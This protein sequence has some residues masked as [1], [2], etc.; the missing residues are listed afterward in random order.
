M[1]EARALTVAGLGHVALFAALSLS[2][3][4]M[5]DFEPGFDDP[6]PVDFVEIGDVPS[7]VE[8][9]PPTLAAAPRETIDAP[10]IEE[11]V[12]EEPEPEP[13]PDLAAETPPPEAT[14]EPVPP[15]PK[16]KPA[17]AKELTQAVDKSV[18]EAPTAREEQDFA[19]AITDALPQQ[20]RLSS[21]QQ[22]TLAQ[23]IKDRIYKCWDPAAGGPASSSI[24]T[25]LRVRAAPSGDI[26]GR[27]TLVR[28]T[29]NADSGYMRAARD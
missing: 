26:R 25:T 2:W 1:S 6:I 4:L 17:P 8:Q 13:L 16:P 27:P 23:A 10:E 22:A 11:E 21:I 7:V 14:P 20:V 3:S 12:P 18:A 19:K 5:A 28:Q 9:P 29:G 24:T 15:E